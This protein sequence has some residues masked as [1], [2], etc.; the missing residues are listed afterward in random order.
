MGVSIFL[1]MVLIDKWSEDELPSMKDMNNSHGF[2]A[3]LIGSGVISFSSYVYHLF[4][5]T[6]PSFFWVYLK[7]IGAAIIMLAVFFFAIAWIMRA[8]P[9]R[10][11]RSYLVKVFDIYGKET[12]IDG[13]RTDFQTHDVAW[14]FMKEYKKSYP[15]YNFALVSDLPNSS[16]MT[17]FRYI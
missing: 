8:K 10:R 14:S 11:P 6:I 4:G 1:R 17:I 13:M 7:E 3:A 16:R 9:H 12:K 5:D 15:F 2:F